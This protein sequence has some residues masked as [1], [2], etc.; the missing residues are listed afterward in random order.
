MQADAV[1][2]L[3]LDTR[4]VLHTSGRDLDEADGAPWDSFPVF[5][6]VGLEELA[7]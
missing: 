2:A 1:L 5:V 6:L 7:G 3:L 4:G